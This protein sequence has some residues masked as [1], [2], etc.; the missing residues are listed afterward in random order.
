[1]QSSMNALWSKA[2]PDLV[3][4]PRKFSIQR[5]HSKQ[6]AVILPN[7]LFQYSLVMQNVSWILINA[8]LFANFSKWHNRNINNMWFICKYIYHPSLVSSFSSSSG[9]E[10]NPLLKVDIRAPNSFAILISK[11]SSL[12][13]VS[14]NNK[15]HSWNTPGVKILH[16]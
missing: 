9:F 11:H 6:L 15:F 12:V 14:W 5:R 4:H 3:N 13:W 2:Q 7:V 10:S 1:M 8:T 16:P